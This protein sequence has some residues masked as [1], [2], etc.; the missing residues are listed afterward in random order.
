MSYTERLKKSFP[1]NLHGL[2]AEVVDGQWAWSDVE[3]DAGSDKDGGGGAVL[4]LANVHLSSE[5]SQLRCPPFRVDGIPWF[6][7]LYRVR[8]EGGAATHMAAYLDAS[9]AL[10]E[11]PDFDKQVMICCPCF[12]S[13]T[14][15]IPL[16]PHTQPCPALQKSRD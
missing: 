2:D 9:H 16:S 12:P 15:S 7:R 3:C 1:P 6:V 10:R 8:Q 13:P 14:Q 11:N 5:D 4:S